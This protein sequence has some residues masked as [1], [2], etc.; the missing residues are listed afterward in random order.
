MR[1]DIRHFPP[2]QEEGVILGHDG[3]LT[4][5]EVKHLQELGYSISHYK[6]YTGYKLIQAYFEGLAKGLIGLDPGVYKSMDALR[7]Q[8]MKLDESSSEMKTGKSAK[9][10]VVTLLTGGVSFDQ[11]PAKRRGRPPGK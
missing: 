10:D 3:T 2:P 11:N 9:V 1:D 4:E 5:E 7:K 6:S 8:F